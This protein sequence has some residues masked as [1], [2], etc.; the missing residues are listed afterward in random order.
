MHKNSKALF[1]AVLKR[2]FLMGF[3]QVVLGGSG[4]DFWAKISGGWR[5]AEGEGLG[6]GGGGFGDREGFVRAE[7]DEA[8]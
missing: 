3:V 8:A 1:N 6:A 4:S 2:A 7:G 5:D